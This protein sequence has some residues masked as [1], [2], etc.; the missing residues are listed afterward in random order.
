MRQQKVTGML[1]QPDMMRAAWNLEKTMTRRLVRENPVD[2]VVFIG[3]DDQPTHEFGMCLTDK[4]VIA[5]HVECPYGRPGD[6]IFAREATYIPP[7]EITGQM[8]REGAETWPDRFYAADGE[9]F[10]LPRLESALNHPS[11]ES[12]EAYIKQW[13]AAHGWRR[14]PAFLMPRK[15]SR[16]C[17]VISQIRVERLQDI[18]GHGECVKE[19][20]RGGHGSIPGYP[21]SATPMEH[22]RHVINRINGKTCWPENPFVWVIGFQPF[23]VNIDTY[24]KNSPLLAQALEVL[25]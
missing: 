6:L 11:K 9:T 23:K 1:F 18:Q 12:D 3:A 19:G 15:Y 10:P 4:R 16:L 8:R 25:P 20:C 14:R 5:K 22:F 24:I 21:Y 13:C 17:G 2:V 7:A